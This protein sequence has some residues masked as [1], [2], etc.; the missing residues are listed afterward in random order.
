MCVGVVCEAD[1]LV[2]IVGDFGPHWALLALVF[3]F[4]YFK[5]VL[6]T[7]MLCHSKRY[8]SIGV[9]FLVVCVG[10]CIAPWDIEHFCS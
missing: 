4:F 10:S 2:Y 3:F 6:E 7:Y 5:G 9:R 8:S 1:L